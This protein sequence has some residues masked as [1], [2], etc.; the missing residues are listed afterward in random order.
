VNNLHND[1]HE[2][3][4]AGYW[5]R[6]CRKLNDEAR[7]LRAQKE[8][9]LLALRDLHDEQNDAP[10]ERRRKQWASAMHRTREVL[11]DLETPNNAVVKGDGTPKA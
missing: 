6:Q 11:R 7:D 5:K 9:L 4:N 8:R 10:L 2:P 3:R 1:E